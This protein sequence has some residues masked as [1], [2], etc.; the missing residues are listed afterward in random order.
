MKSL[1]QT[2][3]GYILSE[4]KMPSPDVLHS[5]HSPKKP[6]FCMISTKHL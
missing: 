4:S 5:F 1:E 6:L 2:S 3:A